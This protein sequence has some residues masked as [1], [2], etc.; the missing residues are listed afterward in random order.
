[1]KIKTNLK[2]IWI[3]TILSLALFI[4]GVVQCNAQATNY[5]PEGSIT[6]SLHQDI[7][8][9]ILKT[10][11]NT[12]FLLVIDML[13]VWHLIYPDIEFNYSDFKLLFESPQNNIK[14]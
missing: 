12:R 2:S 6:V 5:A 10:K 11:K 3:V 7:R 13:M 4:F 8:L 14:I 9:A 1:M